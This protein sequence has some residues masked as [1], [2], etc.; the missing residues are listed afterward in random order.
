[1]SVVLTR[2]AM[3]SP[4]MSAGTASR[5]RTCTPKCRTSGS[6]TPP[7]STRPLYAAQ[8]T[9]GSHVSRAKNAARRT[10]P[11]P[12][13]GTSPTLRCSRSATSS[14]RDGASD[15][16]TVSALIEDPGPALLHVVAASLEAG[17]PGLLERVL[18]GDIRGLGGLL[19]L[20]LG[21][22]A[23]L[24]LRPA[25]LHRARRRACA[26]AFSG[27]EGAL[28]TVPVVVADRPDRGS[29][30]GPAGRALHR[31]ALR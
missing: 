26:C 20:G 28:V 27:V 7:G 15:G 22:L 3:A 14:T 23:G 13:A 4:R 1:M 16:S 6:S 29:P 11:S 18:L 30:R 8:T 12:R 21:L 25:S 10:T 24:L 2:C 17:A 5:K 19:R 9:S 31:P